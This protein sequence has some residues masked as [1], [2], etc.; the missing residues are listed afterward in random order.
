[1]G[2]S[3]AHQMIPLEAVELP[4][5]GWDGWLLTQVGSA[6]DAAILQ[7]MRLAIDAT[8]MPEPGEV[9]ALR[10]SAQRFLEGELWEDPR[11][12]FEFVDQPIAATPSAS[13]NRRV[14]RSGVVVAREFT[15]ARSLP[16]RP[17]CDGIRQVHIVG[18]QHR[19]VTAA[20]TSRRGKRRWPAS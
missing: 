4:R 14:L 12:Y 13:R 2:V 16:R 18:W 3:V 6:L 8:L 1:M 10:A 15:S 11:R 5:E 20:R 7:A 19:V 17:D 9:P